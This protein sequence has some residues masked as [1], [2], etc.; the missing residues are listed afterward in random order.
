MKI[1]F[2]DLKSQY[3]SIKNEIDA[4]INQVLSEAA[5]VGG[6]FLEKFEQE[7][8][9][10]IGA[11][12]C[13]GVGNGTDAIFIALNAL[14]IGPGDEVITAANS[15]IATSEAITMA[16]ADVVFAD[17]DPATFNLDVNDLESRITSRTRAII[18]VHLYGQPAD[19]DP[20]L[21]I[22]KAHNLKVVE[23]SAQAHGSLYKGRRVGT[24]GP[25][26]GMS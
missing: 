1:P 11:R 22:A 3:A 2:V 7:F 19:M 5:F 23:D 20:I 13:I 12:H 18:V 6:P 14:G 8:A 4:S 17:I 15:F 9:A 24:L 26:S 21:K 16:G 10:F 25:P